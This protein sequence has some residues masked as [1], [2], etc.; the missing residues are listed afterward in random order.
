M[1]EV[2][3]GADFLCIEVSISILQCKIPPFDAKSVHPS[4]NLPAVP[5]SVRFQASAFSP[6]DDLVIVGHTPDGEERRVSIGVRRAPELVASE[7]ASV[8]LLSSYL[9]VVTEHWDEVKKG[10]WRLALAVASPNPA[11]QQVRELA[12]IARAAT[13]DMMFQAEVLRPKRTSSGVRKRLPHLTQL[14]ATAVTRSE[15]D[16]GEDS[17]REATWD[18]A[19][20]PS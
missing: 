8:H 3:C 15:M 2:R 19:R 6:V 5:I 7:D 12:E 20:I 4:V 17:V 16:L 13:D 14:V 10:R 18:M 11:V 9:R 1:E